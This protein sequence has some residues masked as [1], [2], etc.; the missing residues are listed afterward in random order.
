MS[1]RSVLL[2]PETPGWT[3]KAIGRLRTLPLAL[4]PRPGTWSEI[5][6]VHPPLARVICLELRTF[7]AV[8]RRALAR[9]AESFA[10]ESVVLWDN[11]VGATESVADRVG[12]LGRRDPVIVRGADWGVWCETVEA[13]ARALGTLLPLVMLALG[14][15]DPRVAEACRRILQQP[16]GATTVTG[17]ARVLGYRSRHTLGARLRPMGIPALP[18]LQWLRLL[19]A[20]DWAEASSDLPTRQ[21]VAARFGYASGDSFGRHVKKVTGRTVV[22]LIEAGPDEVLGMV[23]QRLRVVRRLPDSP[24]PLPSRT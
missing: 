15:T 18:L 6:A 9:L 1:A 24:H 19:A 17:W 10:L 20:V 4:T 11:S 5:A 13:L 3:A 21:A 2:V 22:E 16:D 14:V 12:V 23:R 7:D 8:K